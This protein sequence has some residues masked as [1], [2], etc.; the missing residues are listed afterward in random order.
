MQLTVAS[1]PGPKLDLAQRLEIADSYVSL[2]ESEPEVQLDALKEAH[3]YGFD[4]VV[5]A[6]GAHQVLEE[7][8]K[9]VRKGGKLVVYG[10][11]GDDVKVSWSPSL[12]WTNEITI[13]ASFCETLMFPVAIDYLESKKVRVEGIAHGV[14]RLEQWAEC[15]DAMR[16]QEVVKAV[17]VF[18]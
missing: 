17:I 10:V 8:I 18:G 4:I 9:F 14:Y 16:K 12:M 3:P 1:R 13:V 6:T 15:L 5:E 7:S 2:S 11:Y